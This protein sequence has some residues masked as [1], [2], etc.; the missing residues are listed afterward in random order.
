M[1]SIYRR[2]SLDEVVAKPGSKNRKRNIIMNF[3]VSPEEKTMIDDRIKLSGLSK[4]E[5]FISSCLNQNITTYGN[6]KTFDVMKKDL[7]EIKERLKHIEVSEEM[8]E[9]SLNKL[10]TILDIYKG[11]GMD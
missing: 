8:D 9:E 1:K 11:L 4:S 2:S 3:R 10:K 5:Y 6:V 7:T